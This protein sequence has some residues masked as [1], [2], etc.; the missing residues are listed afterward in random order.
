MPVVFSNLSG[1]V[2]EEEISF[3]TTHGDFIITAC[4]KIVTSWKR[5]KKVHFLINVLTLS[6]P[7][8]FWMPVPGGG[9]GG[10]KVPMA[11]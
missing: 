3:L 4:G 8:C 11:L 5:G 10:E 7:G 9:G 2:Q 6:C 1:P